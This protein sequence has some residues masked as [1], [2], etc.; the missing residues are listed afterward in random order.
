MAMPSNIRFSELISKQKTKMSNKTHWM[1]VDIKRKF[2]KLLSLDAT[3]SQSTVPSILGEN[4]FQLLETHQFS[5]FPW[6]YF[7]VFS[8]QWSR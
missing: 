7:S 3:P 6:T 1:T 5:P 8:W 2:R 4:S